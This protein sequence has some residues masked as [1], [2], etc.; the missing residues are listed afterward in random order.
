MTQKPYLRSHKPIP[1]AIPLRLQSAP[2]KYKL[3][4]QLVF[5]LFIM[6]KNTIINLLM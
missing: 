5:R 1:K 4:C 3:Y 2:S 6:S